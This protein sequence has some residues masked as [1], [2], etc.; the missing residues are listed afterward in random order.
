MMGG[1]DR[2][3]RWSARGLW[4]L[5]GCAASTPAP[6]V[7]VAEPTPAP[8]STEAAPHAETHAI[9]EPVPEP[10]PEPTTVLRQDA[11]EIGWIESLDQIE[12]LE[13]EGDVIR[14]QLPF[15][16]R[17]GSRS[18]SIEARVSAAGLDALRPPQI[19]PAL[20]T[21]VHHKLDLRHADGTPLAEARCGD[22]EVLVEQPDRTRVRVRK[23]GVVLEG[24]VEGPV[25]RRGTEECPP[26][27]L[28]RPMQAWVKGQ[29]RPEPEPLP[30]GFVETRAVQMKR[31]G[32]VWWLVGGEQ[33]I[34]QRWSWAKNG[35]VLERRT[36]DSRTWY[37]LG[38]DATGSSFILYGPS[39]Q[40][41]RPHGGRGALGCALPVVVVDAD[42][43]RWV[44]VSTLESFDAYHR[45]DAQHWYRNARA[46]QQA[47]ASMIGARAGC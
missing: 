39:W 41:L 21:A 7:P 46:C 16:R 13:R 15:Y 2:S 29:P 45:E 31:R 38:D 47:L 30:A 10:E 36:E 1:M 9:P 17:E 42:E 19:G 32:S 3:I 4:L 6:V 27:V 14:V 33:P 40:S 44:I 28:R 25:T 35:T 34:C 11:E 26:R 37:A 8:S 43:D 22:V 12:I 5:V 20:R 18:L 23:R 24:W